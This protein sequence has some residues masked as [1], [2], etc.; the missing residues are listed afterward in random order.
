MSSIK[1]KDGRL[2]LFFSVLSSGEDKKGV[3]PHLRTKKGA[4]DINSYPH[5]NIAAILPKKLFE[6]LNIISL[7]AYLQSTQ[8]FQ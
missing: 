5:I 3:C 7:Q 8:S 2:P 4:M 6:Q 1:A